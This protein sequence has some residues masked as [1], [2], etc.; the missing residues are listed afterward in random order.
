MV[1]TAT[2]RAMTI[3]VTIGQLFSGMELPFSIENVF[4]I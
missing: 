3:I 1:S 4:T 2:E